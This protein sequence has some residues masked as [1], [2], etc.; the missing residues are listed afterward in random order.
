MASRLKLWKRFHLDCKATCTPMDQFLSSQNRFKSMSPMTLQ[1]FSWLSLGKRRQEWPKWINQFKNYA[2]Q[3]HIY[4]STSSSLT[5][6]A[7]KNSVLFNIAQFSGGS[8]A[9]GRSGVAKTVWQFVK[10]LRWIRIFSVCYK[11]S[12]SSPWHNRRRCSIRGWLRKK[13]RAQ[14]YRQHRRHNELCRF[15]RYWFL[16]QSADIRTEW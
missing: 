1:F 2:F 9:I 12:T 6:A 15:C 3:V 10:F 8:I 4:F 16:P 11:L 14:L 5:S 13:W 7:L